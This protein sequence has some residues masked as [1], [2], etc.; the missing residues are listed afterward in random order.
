MRPFGS[1]HERQERGA[2]KERRLERHRRRR[3]GMRR[4]QGRDREEM[5]IKERDKNRLRDCR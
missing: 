1:K 2:E 3:K 4:T 5:D